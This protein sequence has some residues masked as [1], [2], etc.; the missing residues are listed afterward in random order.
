M[1]HI[2]WTSFSNRERHLTIEEIKN[3]VAKYGYI[4]DFKQFS[5]LSLNLT[6]EIEDLKVAGLYKDLKNILSMEDYEDSEAVP[7]KEKTVFLNVT[8]LTGTGNL[9]NVVPAVPG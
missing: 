5:D 2:F 8:F 9:K 6:I 7:G 4:V 1:K 3:T